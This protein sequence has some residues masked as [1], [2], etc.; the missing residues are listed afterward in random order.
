MSDSITPSSSSLIITAHLLV[1]VVCVTQVAATPH[2]QPTGVCVRIQQFS[3]SR[4]SLASVRSCLLFRPSVLWSLS[5]P[6]C[7][8]PSFHPT[9]TNNTPLRL[10][11]D[12]RGCRVLPLE[13][14]SVTHAKD[15]RGA[16]TGTSTLM[17]RPLS[18]IIYGTVHEGTLFDRGS[19]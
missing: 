7:D 3:R 18:T 13:T 17:Y 15:S 2:S 14:Q 9:R 5:L 19:S 16:A 11:H 6:P 10:L 8:V 12:F 4:P 1:L